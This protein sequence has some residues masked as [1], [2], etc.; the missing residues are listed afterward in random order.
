MNNLLT[1]KEVSDLFKVH[2]QSVYRNR[3]LPYIKIPGIGLRYRENDLR[4]Y[5]E[6][7][8]IKP[9]PMLI[10]PDPRKS[11]ELKELEEFDKLYLNKNKGGNCGSMKEKKIRW[12]YGFGSIYI[13]K[14]KQGKDRWYAEYYSEGMRVREVIKNAQNRAE[15]VFLQIP[16]HSGH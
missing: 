5:L 8:T 14:T 9:K 13:R 2:P 1:V 15:A 16:V 7:K 10:T 3:L 6:Q 12:N 4:E 11:I